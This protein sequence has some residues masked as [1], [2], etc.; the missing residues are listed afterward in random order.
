MAAPSF[1]FA[2][3]F[4]QAGSSLQRFT[5]EAFADILTISPFLNIHADAAEP[6]D[7]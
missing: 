7:T 5:R 3:P 4:L 2:T 6:N 1:G